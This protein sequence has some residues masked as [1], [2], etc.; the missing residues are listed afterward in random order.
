MTFATESA[1]N[2]AIRR[3]TE[4]RDN[5]EAEQLAVYVGHVTLD[6]LTEEERGRPLEP[7]DDCLLLGYDAACQLDVARLR[8]LFE[9]D[10]WG[11]AW[12]LFKSE[13]TEWYEQD[14][15]RV[16]AYNDA[17]QILEEEAANA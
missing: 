8:Q 16:L 6:K 2:R 7:S 12:E 14:G 11:S 13:D 5:A 17:L 3:L 4:L 15:G 9:E 1:L 10:D